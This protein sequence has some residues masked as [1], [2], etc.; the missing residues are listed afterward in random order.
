MKINNPQEELRRDIEII[1]TPLEDAEADGRDLII[2]KE[3]LF[4][5]ID[6]YLAEREQAV[7]KEF[8]LKKLPDQEDRCDNC[9]HIRYYHDHPKGTYLGRVP[10][11]SFISP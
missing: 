10:C 5:L 8:N 3:K 7:K 1:I 11:K 2:F 9:G 6:K 4:R